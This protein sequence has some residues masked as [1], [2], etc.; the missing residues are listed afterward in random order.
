MYVHFC[1]C[2]SKVLHMWMNLILRKS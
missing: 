2:S 1:I